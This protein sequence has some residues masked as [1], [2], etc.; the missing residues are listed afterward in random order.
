MESAGVVST[1]TPTSFRL[2]WD[3]FLSF[4]GED[5]RHGIT[6]TLYCSLVGEGL[7]VF[8]DDDALRRGDEIAPSLMEAIEDSAAFVVILSEN[9]ASSHWCLEELARICELNSRSRSRRLVLPVFYGVDPSH[10]R[11][12]EG[13]FKEDFFSHENR[14][15]E[16]QAYR[17]REAMAKVGSL[18]GFVER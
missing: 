11:K 15:G 16:K 18:A 2:R 3:V 4:R 10:V 6:H 9:Y 5:T 7:R 17:W 12:Q 13:R 14:F 1:T 8:R